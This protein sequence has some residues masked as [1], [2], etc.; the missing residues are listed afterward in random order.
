MT[1][2]HE[3]DITLNKLIEEILWNQINKE[4]QI[5]KH[6]VKEF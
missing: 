4:D 2:A 5:K 6:D 1:L 3:R